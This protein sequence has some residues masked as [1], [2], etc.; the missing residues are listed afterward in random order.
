MA[1][2]RV[3]VDSSADMAY[4]SMSSKSVDR[5]VELSES[6]NLDIA[7]DGTICGVELMSPPSEA[8]KT[9]REVAVK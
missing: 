3:Y 1:K 7:S 5:T 4:L 8:M 2:T 6:I 9:L